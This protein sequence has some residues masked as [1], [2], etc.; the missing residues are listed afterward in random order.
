MS[1]IIPIL[2]VTYGLAAAGCYRIMREHQGKT[3][4]GLIPIYNMF[5]VCGIVWETWSYLVPLC[6]GIVGVITFFFVPG[7][8]MLI[9]CLSI[10]VILVYRICFSLLTCRYFQV[11]K[12]WIA[13]GVSCMSLFLFTLSCIGRQE[14]KASD[15]FQTMA[16][17]AGALSAPTGQP[18]DNPML[19]GS[20]NDSHNEQ[21]GDKFWQNTPTKMQAN[22]NVLALEEELSENLQEYMAEGNEIGTESSVETAKKTNPVSRSTDDHTVS[23]DLVR[24]PGRTR[25]RGEVKEDPDEGLSENECQEQEGSSALALAGVIHDTD[26]QEDNNTTKGGIDAASVASHSVVSTVPD[27][28][29]PCVIP[30]SY[31]SDHME[32]ATVPDM[33]APEAR[34]ISDKTEKKLQASGGSEADGMIPMK[35]WIIT[36]LLSMIPVGGIVFLVYWSAGKG[37]YPFR[38]PFARAFIVCVISVALVVSVI[39]AGVYYSYFHSIL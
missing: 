17:T 16:R 36:I 9:P 15:R 13:V 4:K 23:E 31:A 22:V 29:V 39:C 19:A 11:S 30:E 18:V 8:D 34:S 6:A 33:P 7:A 21:E 32:L 25:E 1:V 27:T 5:S 3:W 10:A 12:G 28:A 38:V 24:S 35:Q 37:Q 20:A 14:K 26:D 2:A